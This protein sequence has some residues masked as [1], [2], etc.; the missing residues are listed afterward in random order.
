MNANPRDSAY[1]LDSWWIHVLRL[2]VGSA[3]KHRSGSTFRFRAFDKS[4][5]MCGNVLRK[6]NMILRSQCH[7][8]HLMELKPGLQRTPESMKYFNIEHGVSCLSCLVLSARIHHLQAY[9][10]FS[11]VPTSDHI[12]EIVESK[13]G[14]QS[15]FQ[16][17]AAILKAFVMSFWAYQLHEYG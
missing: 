11:N 17:L 13:L 14:A 4:D 1:Q 6:G 2:V 5:G 12:T 9:V 15:R 7:H 10:P 3:R 16:I 8:H